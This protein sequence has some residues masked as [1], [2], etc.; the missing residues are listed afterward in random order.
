V[1]FALRFAGV[2]AVE[3]LRTFGFQVD[4]GARGG[5]DYGGAAENGGEILLKAAA[6]RAKRDNPTITS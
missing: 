2:F 4:I 3:L 6:F 5:V 1:R